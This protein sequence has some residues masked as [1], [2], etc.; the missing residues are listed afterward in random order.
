MNWVLERLVEGKHV[1][2]VE[3]VVSGHTCIG[4]C[5][6]VTHGYPSAHSRVTDELEVI[7]RIRDEYELRMANVPNIFQM[8]MGHTMFGEVG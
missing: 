4:I 5:S 7:T 1:Y 6:S 8:T 3:D 2:I